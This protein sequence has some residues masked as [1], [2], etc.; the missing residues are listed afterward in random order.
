MGMTNIEVVRNAERLQLPNFKYFMR[1]ELSN[2]QPDDLEC[3]FVN[4]NKSTEEGSHH[5]CYWKKGD[6][7]Y[8]FDSFGVI[9]PKE[10]IEYLKS[11]ILYSTYQIQKFN[12]SNCSEWCLFVLNKLNKGKNYIDIILDI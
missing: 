3:G 9:P 11:P 5:V 8:Y 2:K 7:K 4:L 1:D 6:N 12:D 10:V